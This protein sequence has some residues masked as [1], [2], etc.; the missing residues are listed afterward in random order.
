MLGFNNNYLH[1]VMLSKANFDIN[2]KRLEKT[3][4]MLNKKHAKRMQN[5]LASPRQIGRGTVQSIPSLIQEA[6]I[7]P[8]T[9]WTF[10]PSWFLL[11]LFAYVVSS[12]CLARIQNLE[13]RCAKL[14]CKGHPTPKSVARSCCCYT[15]RPGSPATFLLPNRRCQTK[16]WLCLS[17]L[18]IQHLFAL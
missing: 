8:Q 3:Y 16:S 18:Q 4:L 12:P 14:G 6:T 17:G 11:G 13:A 10:S 9:V 5:I 1:V 7:S 15:I 2:I